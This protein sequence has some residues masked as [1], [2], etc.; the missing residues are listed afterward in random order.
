MKYP[1]K[2]I[3]FNVEHGFCGFI[4]CPNGHTVLIDCGKAESF[5]PVKYILDS[6]LADTVLHNGYKLTE[7]ILTHPHDDHL[8]DIAR[9]R[10]DFPPA[11]LRRESRYNW[12]SLKVSNREEYENL[13]IYSE[14][15]AGYQYPVTDPPDWGIEIIDNFKLSPQEAYE[16]N[17]DNYVNNSS[18][19]VIIRFKGTQY[20]EKILFG[21]DLMKEGWAELLRNEAFADNL[22]DINFFIASHHGH[23]S[24]YCKEVFD[25]MGSPPILNIIS[26]HR[27][28]ESVESAYSSLSLG[29]NVN[30]QERHMLSTRNDGSIILE[31]DSEGK[32]SVTTGNFPDNI[33]SLGYWPRY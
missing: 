7:F 17:K 30:G 9:L 15:Q 8:E 28:D 1:L 32:Y 14:W 16:I 27:R 11:I 23:S 31:I 6:E 12:E 18:I 29:T 5:S 13:D 3:I 26:A 10:S 24:G 4:K 21:G 2:V 33:G 19:P 20:E 25:A 22:R